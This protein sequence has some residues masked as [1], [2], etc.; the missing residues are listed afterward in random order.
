MSGLLPVTA[1]PGTAPPSFDGTL[2]DI[3]FSGG[4][5]S[6][7][8]SAPPPPPGALVA[9]G[10][11]LAVPDAA[12][13]GSD[14]GALVAYLQ[15]LG[16]HINANATGFQQASRGATAGWIADANNGLTD[17]QPLTVRLSARAAAR[18]S[19]YDMHPATHL[20]TFKRGADA[21][22]DNL[23]SSPPDQLSLRNALYFCPMLADEK[24]IMQR[25]CK[26][27]AIWSN[28]P[29]ISSS[30][31][32]V[33]GAKASQD[34][35]L[36][37]QQETKCKLVVPVLQ[38]LSSAGELGSLIQGIPHAPTRDA[39]LT[40]LDTHT[41][42]LSDA[43]HVVAYE[44]TNLQKRRKT[45]LLQAYSG[46]SGIA[47]E[48]PAT[49]ADRSLTGETS[50]DMSSDI[51]AVAAAHRRTARELAQMQSFRSRGGG[52]AR[53]GGQHRAAGEGRSR[54]AQ[55][56]RS[57]AQRGRG[58]GRGRGRG[59][60]RGQAKKDSPPA[61]DAAL[62][63]EDGGGRGRGRV[64]VRSIVFPLFNE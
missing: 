20:S 28:P 12:T 39:L 40:V 8:V 1:T 55:R 61:A 37:E 5:W 34:T 46:V 64:C 52:Q 54:N 48:D 47:V 49:D 45:L 23:F 26:K 17:V 60:H 9:F 4:L 50:I 31:T 59:Q 33:L 57:Q 13:L 22:I 30:E 21:T 11:T 14:P 7:A 15:S 10:D 43:F 62:Q 29:T 51:V 24:A 27:P 44:V 16:A 18:N 56:R 42:E 32:A 41:S 3:D 53:G 6:L 36:R 19:Q 2:G 35:G 58:G 25:A 63:L 38:A